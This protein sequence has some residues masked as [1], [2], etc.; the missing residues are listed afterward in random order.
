[1]DVNFHQLNLTR[2]S[3]YLPLPDRTANKKAVTNPRNEADEECF[4]WA[5]IAALHYE[6]IGNDPQRI[7]K[8]RRFEGNCEWGGFPVALNKIDA[9]ERK[10]DVSVNV[11]GIVGGKEKPYILRK[12]KFDGQ[13][14]ANLLL[15]DQGGK[16]H[17]A[18]IKNL[19]RL[20][21][22]SNSDTT[23]A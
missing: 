13:R 18:V 10:N 6:E 23:S 2:G 19:S 3:Y 8:V 1:M 15:I 17:Y 14:T 21:A 20:L 16:G 9:F 22:S 4:K 5:V 7:S 12:S 11:L